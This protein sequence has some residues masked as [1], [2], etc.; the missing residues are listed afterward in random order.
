MEENEVQKIIN[1]TIQGNE[2]PFNKFLEETFLALYS[3][4]E[5]LMTTEDD[6]KDI[7]ENF[8]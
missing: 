7:H 8:Y 2:F 4:L 3:R 6:S 1:D 5:I